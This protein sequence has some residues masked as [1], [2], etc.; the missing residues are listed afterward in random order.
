MTPTPDAS[1]DIL[2]VGLV[3][4]NFDGVFADNSVWV[5]DDGREAVRCTR[6]DSI[7]LSRLRKLG[8]K[9]AILS[10]EINPLAGIR[11]RKMG[12]DCL[13]GCSDKGGEFRW[14]VEKRG[15]PLSQTA[16]V[17]ND[18]NELPALA[19]AGFPIAVVGSLREVLD[20]A[21]W[22]TTQGEAA[23]REVCGLIVDAHI[24]TRSVQEGSNAA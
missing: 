24:R 17:G 14:M 12:I 10:T 4:F 18:L 9:T 16:Y 21:L 23:V 5:F 15:I 8:I 19:I 11:V 2:G 7:G 1:R 6:A 3:V 20:H 22:E 13:Q